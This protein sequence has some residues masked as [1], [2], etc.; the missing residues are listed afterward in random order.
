MYFRIENIKP[1]ELER[2]RRMFGRRLTS[3]SSAHFLTCFNEI[4]TA[5]EN[6]LTDQEFKEFMNSEYMPTELNI[7]AEDLYNNYSA[8]QF[9]ELYEYA[10]RVVHEWSETNNE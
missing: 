4:L 2:L 6:Q 1:N 7:M 5:L 3:T 10:E 9:D 8:L